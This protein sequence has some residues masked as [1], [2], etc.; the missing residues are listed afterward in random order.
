[1]KCRL[2]TLRILAAFVP[3]IPLV[4]CGW[5]E[6]RA[7]VPG[8][9]GAAPPTT[10][11]P[12]ARRPPAAVAPVP[13]PSV[14][15]PSAASQPGTVVVQTGDSLYGIARRHNVSPRG[16][17][18][19][20][21]LRPPYNLLVG[22]RLTLPVSREHVVREGDTLYGISRRYDVDMYA[23]ARANEMGPPYTILTGQRLR[24][25]AAT[26]GPPLAATDGAGTAGE[27]TV[28]DR[29]GPLGPA[30]T[31]RAA[32]EGQPPRPPDPPP[33]KGAGPLQFRWP[34]RGE[35]ISAFGPKAQGRHNDGI[36]IAVP[37]GTEVRAAEAGVVVYA[38]NELRGF[39]NLILIKHAEGWITAYAHA[40][41]IL[42]TRNQRIRRGEVIARVGR[43]GGLDR[44]QLHFEMRRGSRAVDPQQH[45]GVRPV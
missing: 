7:P 36:N 1:M 13:R 28:D 33:L 19:A 31:M 35:V 18:D 22:Q 29:R 16:L 17:I 3:A 32:P 6:V 20:N 27:K 10:Q 26:L 43:T 38:G 4:A 25:P 30:V 14:A 11:G 21:G 34:V 15:S 42:V 41:E 8:P 40:E 5:A 23:L 44:P 9:Y 24:L 2:R 37:A 39:G 12:S 45:L